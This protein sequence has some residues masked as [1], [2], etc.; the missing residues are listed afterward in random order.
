MEPRRSKY[1]SI[2][3]GTNGYEETAGSELV[4]ITAGLPREAGC[5]P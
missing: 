5:E 2:L 1:D 3:R 4:V